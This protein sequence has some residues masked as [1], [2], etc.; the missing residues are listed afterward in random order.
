MRNHKREFGAHYWARHFLFLLCA[1][2]QLAQMV[3]LSMEFFQADLVSLPG[4]MPVFN[5][6]LTGVYAAIKEGARWVHTSIG[7]KPGE[8]FFLTWWVF[9][10]MML[11]VSAFHPDRYAVPNGTYE[12]CWFVSIVYVCSE[13]SKFFH[14]ILRVEVPARKRHRR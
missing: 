2:W 6:L 8:Y 7:R 13:T 3:C 10:L 5:L 14:S 12:N 11:L 4:E 1:A 9:A